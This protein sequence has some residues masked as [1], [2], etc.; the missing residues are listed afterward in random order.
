MSCS[1][2][3][4]ILLLIENH[5]DLMGGKEVGLAIHRL[6]K[7]AGSGC[8]TGLGGAEEGSFKSGED[9]RVA[10]AAAAIGRQATKIA[11]NLAPSDLSRL[12]WGFATLGL[13]PA[14]DVME[15]V[16]QCIMMNVDQF[17]S[18]TVVSFVW[19]L[20]KIGLDPDPR[21]FTT[22]M[23]RAA[24]TARQLTTQVRK[25]LMSDLHEW[26]HTSSRVLC[27]QILWMVLA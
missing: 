24:A 2:S 20:A 17:E 22:M 18:Q 27:L 16:A 26:M 10:A 23:S 13:C 5:S 19:A 12:L 15:T 6:A 25:Y 7:L 8:C 1:Q 21:I 9:A 3:K 11:D 14:P 4:D